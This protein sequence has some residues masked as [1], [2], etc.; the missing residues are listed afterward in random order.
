MVEVM[1]VNEVAAFLR[2]SKTTVLKLSHT[3]DLPSFAIGRRILFR[4]DKVQEF[5]EEKEKE[6]VQ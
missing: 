1:T 2:V 4:A 5:I 6:C 3:G